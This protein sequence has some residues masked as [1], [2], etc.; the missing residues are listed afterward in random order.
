[1][2]SLSVPYQSDEAARAALA[3]SPTALPVA[4][5]ARIMSSTIAWNAEV[6]RH[7]VCLQLVRAMEKG[8]NDALK[9]RVLP[10]P[11]TTTAG[12]VAPSGAITSTAASTEAELALWMS[13]CAVHLVRRGGSLLWLPPVLCVRVVLVVLVTC[14]VREYIGSDGELVFALLVHVWRFLYFVGVCRRCGLVLP[15]STIAAVSDCVDECVPV[16]EVSRPRF[17]VDPVALAVP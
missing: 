1:M 9:A 7:L 12:K 6:G 13:R 11:L 8:I 15:P 5:Y 14:V 17:A 3:L 2:L 4:L 16:A 10:P